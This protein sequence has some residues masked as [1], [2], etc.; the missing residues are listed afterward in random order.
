MY[1]TLK[2][3]TLATLSA[4]IVNGTY[5]PLHKSGKKI[6]Q[7]GF[8]L[9]ADPELRKVIGTLCSVRSRHP[10][11]ITM[12]IRDAVQSDT[13]EA[14]VIRIARQK[15]KRD[16][17]AR[18]K[19]SKME[20]LDIAYETTFANTRQE[21]ENE[22][23]SYGNAMGY[24]LKYLQEQ[25]KGRKLLQNGI[26]NTIPTMSK[27]RST[28]KPYALRMNPTPNPGERTTDKDRIAYLREVLPLMMD[29][30]STRQLLP[31]VR[32][33][34]TTLVR[35]LPVV[36]EMYAN[37]L[38]SRLKAE[39]EALVQAMSSPQDN[40]W[41][42]KLCNEYIG[43][44]LYDGGYFEVFAVQYVPNKTSNR[45]PCWEA[46]TKPVFEDDNGDFVVHERH[47]AT[48]PNGTR[49]LLKSSMVGFALAEY[50]NGHFPKP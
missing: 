3:R 34:N 35:T 26:Y 12:Y 1:P 23:Q 14:E 36:S 22:M 27:F 46:T 39:Q 11:R 30:D 47:F 25:F 10:G 42:A 31:T 21:L 13:A 20:L 48:G 45:F 32:P 28:T 40:P 44:R 50:S 16:K 5:K 38:V 17:K 6:V 18:A 37:P 4:A 9:R 8:G 41:L 19:A 29:E 33:K 7:A 49:T 43:K 2:L 15:A 24:S